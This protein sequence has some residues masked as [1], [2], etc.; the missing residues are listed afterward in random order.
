MKNLEDWWK[1]W[2]ELKRIDTFEYHTVK[3]MREC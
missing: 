1:P 2:L 3:V